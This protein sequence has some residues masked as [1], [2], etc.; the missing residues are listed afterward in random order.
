MKCNM[1]HDS[2]LRNVFC[3]VLLVL[4]SNSFS[5]AEAPPSAVSFHV[6]HPKVKLYWGSDTLAIEKIVE[7]N[8]RGF[9][10]TAFAYWAFVP[11]TVDCNVRMVFD[12]CKLL[13][14]QVHLRLSL[15]RGNDTIS[16]WDSP[17]RGPGEVALRGYPLPLEARESLTDLLKNR[18]VADNEQEIKTQL[19]LLVPLAMGGAWMQLT[20]TN[21][22]MLISPLEWQRYKRLSSSV[23][24]IECQQ[25]SQP[26]SK[27][28]LR[29]YG[30]K[31]QFTTG[32]ESY[33]ALALL[34][35][36]QLAPHK[37]LR[38]PIDSSMTATIL[39]LVPRWL[40]LEEEIAPSGYDV[41]DGAAQGDSL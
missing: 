11:D 21:Q 30:D 33:E 36:E 28:W 12:V 1:I 31:A 32:S 25:N 29:A 17:W 5:R 10:N 35:K 15:L 14:N 2:L 4:I 24:R 40:Y 9:L 34:A 41:F 23:F 37:D 39:I 38:T 22:P 16:Q 26:A 7:S 13:E 3:A 19:R 8:M 18:V 6:S 27:V 20:E